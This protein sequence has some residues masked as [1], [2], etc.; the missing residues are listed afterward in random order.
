MC[1]DRQTLFVFFVVHSHMSKEE[2]TEKSYLKK[3]R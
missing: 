1:D 3:Q 2:E